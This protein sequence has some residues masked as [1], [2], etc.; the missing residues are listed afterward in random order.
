MNL[1]FLIFLGVIFVLCIIGVFIIEIRRSKH[2]DNYDDEEMERLADAAQRGENFT[3]E[4]IE[5][6][7]PFTE[8]VVIPILKKL[9][10]NTQR[11]EIK[12]QDKPEKNLLDSKK[13]FNMSISCPKFLSKKFESIFLLQ[14]FL[15]KEYT[16]V[17]SNIKVEFQD[18][19]ISQHISKSELSKGDKIKVKFFHPDFLF[20]DA[21]TKSI[22]HPLNK[23][24]I[25]GKP[26]DNC[27]PGLHKILVSI[28]DAETEQELES[29]TF[30][31]DVVDFIFGN[32][33]R[34]LLSKV[35][36]IILGIGSFTMFTLALLEQIDKT[37]GLTSGTAAGVLTLAISANF[38]TLY[39]H[40]RPVTP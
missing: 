20:S 28:S 26:K 4:D 10:V 15:A 24:I 12:E 18:Q 31:A 19:E 39:Q 3:L 27:E 2:S 11:L 30:T 25:L 1:S 29:F 35:S 34:P 33:S 5:L 32:I 13:G 37:V 16:K 22:D 40:V 9:G 8:R 21:V 23:I 38:Y 7:Q 36:A 17:K 6:L 14:L